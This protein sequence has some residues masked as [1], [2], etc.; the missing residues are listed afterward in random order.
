[1]NISLKIAI[2]AASLTLAALLTNCSGS[3]EGAA[4][5]GEPV[6]T[7]AEPVFDEASGQFSLSAEADS[8]EGAELRFL[9]L[10]GD[11][12][13]AE[14]TDGQFAAIAPFEE[15]YDL[16]LQAMWPDTVIERICHI[17]DFVL[18]VA[19]VEKISAEELAA[20]ISAKD[21]SL[22]LGTNEHVAQDVDLRI[23]DSQMQAKMLP[24]VIVLIENGVWKGVEV[25]NLEYNDKNL[26]TAV[27]LR[28][29][30]E[31]ADVIDEDD[32]DYDY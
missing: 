18:P 4:K 15:G 32:I 13:V 27:A 6:L 7:A 29:L 8:V 1:M 9:L 20:L 31:Q 12:I 10:L 30:G 28:P 25:V 17:M 24:D 3:G 2:T 11:S 5:R 22:R 14:N 23:V 21:A 16:K 19:P 26:V